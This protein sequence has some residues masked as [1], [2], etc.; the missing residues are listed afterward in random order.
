MKVNHVNQKYNSAKTSRKQIPAL[1]RHHTLFN[2]YVLDYG[3]GRYDLGVNYLRDLGF[4]AEVYDPFNRSMEHNRKVLASRR[5]WDTVLLSNVL[6][7]IAEKEVR[8][9]IIKHCLKLGKELFITVY[10]DSIKEEGETKDGYQMQKPLRFYKNE[11][12]ECGF[13]CQIIRNGKVLRVWN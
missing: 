6:N 7:V 3:G 13:H 4:D 2:Q 5:C 10:Y 9:E 1:H 12:E 8:V 11:I